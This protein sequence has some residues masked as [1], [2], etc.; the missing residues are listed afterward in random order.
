MCTC[1]LHP[2][3]D[4]RRNELLISGGADRH[5][6]TGWIAKEP[7]RWQRPVEFGCHLTDLVHALPELL[8]RADRGRT[9]FYNASDA[10]SESPQDSE[11]RAEAGEGKSSTNAQPP[12]KQET[13]TAWSAWVRIRTSCLVLSPLR[14][15]TG[16]NRFR[17]QRQESRH[18]F[19]RS[20]R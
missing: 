13:A 2:L 5:R 4:S 16:L 8:K 14:T 10:L 17:S 11:V 19:G 18:C 12:R 3:A 1:L 7:G 20:R 6:V 9:G 15:L